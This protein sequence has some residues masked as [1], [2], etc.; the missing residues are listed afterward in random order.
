MQ[1]SYGAGQ[2]SALG[3]MGYT[4]KHINEHDVFL[5]I[6]A[7][8]ATSA[9]GMAGQK[10]TLLGTSYFYT[11]C[12]NE[13][14]VSFLRLHQI[15]DVSVVEKALRDGIKKLDVA[16]VRKNPAQFFVQAYNQT[17]GAPEFINAKDP[18]IDMVQAIHASMAV[19]LVYNK[20]VAIGDSH[21]SDGA[22]D[23]PMPIVRAIET[24]K[25]T[26]VLILPNTPFNRVPPGEPSKV[27]QILINAIP[28]TGSFGFIRKVLNNRQAL[29][30]SL[31]A[32][33]SHQHVKIGVAWPPEMDLEVFTQ[34]AEKIKTAIKASAQSVF[35]L[36]GEERRHLKLYEEVYGDKFV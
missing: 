18:L 12:V 33:A 21:Y 11:V 5:G 4:S 25:P 1:G 24:F 32:I 34:D 14:F 17:K 26:H 10:Q 23:D 16:A 35:T 29:R 27:A 9:F 31:E 15:M 36:F 20:A 6:S 28:S 7:G 2:M 22:F 13:Q 8:A 30:Q 3:E 19:P